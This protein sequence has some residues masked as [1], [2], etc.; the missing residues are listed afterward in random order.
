MFSQGKKSISLVVTSGTLLS[1]SVFFPIVSTNAVKE[2]QNTNVGNAIWWTFTIGTF[3]L[4][5][6]YWYFFKGSDDGDSPLFEKENVGINGMNNSK[7]NSP[8]TEGPKKNVIENSKL[9][10]EQKRT[11]RQELEE[12]IKR[13]KIELEKAKNEKEDLEYTIRDL[14]EDIESNEKKIKELPHAMVLEF[15][16]KAKELNKK[17]RN[18]KTRKRKR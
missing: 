16:K 17:S 8:G 15:N 2:N 10:I 3:G 12:T 11:K 7:F 6:L 14:K 5:A 4:Y 9:K 1:T 18:I 13:F